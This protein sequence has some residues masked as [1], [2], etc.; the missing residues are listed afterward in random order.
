MRKLE[1]DGYIRINKTQARKAY[2]AG[3]DVYMVPC[4]MRL[5]NPW[6][7][8]YIASKENR[9]KPIASDGFNTIIP[10][11]DEFDTIVNCFSYYN[12]NYNELGKYPAY[13]IKEA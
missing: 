13:Y 4:K 1:F 9:F 7:V 8:P 3:K 11:N 10:R 6:Q 12:C 5:F 2:N